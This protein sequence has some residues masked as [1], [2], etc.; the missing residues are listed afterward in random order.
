MANR[1]GN[2]QFISNEVVAGLAQTSV[3]PQQKPTNLVAIDTSWRFGY[4]GCQYCDSFAK[5]VSCSMCDDI[6]GCDECMWTVNGKRLCTTC[7][8]NIEHPERKGHDGSI[9]LDA[10]GNFVYHQ[11]AKVL[12]FPVGATPLAPERGS[13]TDKKRDAKLLE[14]LDRAHRALLGDGSNLKRKQLAGELKR[15][16][17]A[18][19][20]QGGAA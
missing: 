9:G 13:M 8:E 18:L 1:K 14:S 16:I 17:E 5:P 4:E 11:L 7:K 3:N 19:L 10:S 20:E 6:E 12:M 2:T 15:E